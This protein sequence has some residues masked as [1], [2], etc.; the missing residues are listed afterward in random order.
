MTDFTDIV[1]LKCNSPS[2]PSLQMMA[3][4]QVGAGGGSGYTSAP[5]VTIVGG[6]AT[7]NATATAT[8]NSTYKT[9]TS[10][11]VNSGGG[12]Y[13]SF[14]AVYISNPQE[15]GDTA[16]AM[17]IVNFQTGIV[18]Q[19]ILTGAKGKAGGFGYIST[20]TVSIS[21]AGSGASA[22]AEYEGSPYK[23]VTRINI[24][25]EGSGYSPDT[26]IV[27]ISEPTD[28]S[29]PLADRKVATA[30]AV[31]EDEYIKAIF[32][33][34]ELPQG[35][36][37]ERFLDTTTG[38][39]YN[40][41]YSE[42]FLLT[43]PA[44]GDHIPFLGTNESFLVKKDLQVGG[45]VASQQG[46]IVLNHG[47]R[48]KPVLSSPPCISLDSS[49]IPYPYVSSDN[50][51]PSNAEPGQLYNSGG[52]HKMFDGS[53]WNPG[54]FSGYYDTLFLFQFDGHTPA[55]LDLGNLTVHGDLLVDGEIDASVS[56]LFVNGV[57]TL[58][59]DNSIK[60][61]TDNH[62][63]IGE[64][65]KMWQNMYTR[66]L[67]LG[68]N[69]ATPTPQYLTFSI[70]NTGLIL[71]ITSSSSSGSLLP[72]SG[73]QLDLGS[74]S[75]KWNAIYC[76]N[77]TAN[78]I[79]S[80]TT[81]TIN[82]GLTVSGNANIS[83]YAQFNNNA[84]LTWVNTTTLA[85]TDVNGVTDKAGLDVGSIFINS[86]QPLN[87]GSPAGININCP[88]NIG[89]SRGTSGQVLTS[90]GSGSSPTWQ[91]SGGWNGGT[92]STPIIIDYN[93]A[94]INLDIKNTSDASSIL[95]ISNRW[96]TNGDKAWIYLGDN[97][98][99]YIACTYGGTLDFQS[100]NGFTWGTQNGSNRMVLDASGNC[101]LT[102]AL[103]LQGYAQFQENMVSREA[104]NN[105]QM[106]SN[107]NRSTNTQASAS[108]PSWSIAVGADDS[109][110]FYRMPAA[111]GWSQLGQINASGSFGVAG[112]ITAGSYIVTQQTADNSLHH[113]LFGQSGKG[114]WAEYL[115]GTTSGGN[116]GND[117]L[118]LRYG[119]DASF[120][121]Q[122]LK[123][124]RSNGAI[125][126]ANSC[127]DNGV[128]SMELAGYIKIGGDNY[129]GWSNGSGGWDVYMR[130]A[131]ANVLAI[132]NGSGG[133]GAL[134]CSIM[135][136]DYWQPTATGYL[137]F[138]NH[139]KSYSTGLGIYPYGDNN[140]SLGGNGAGVSGYPY[141]GSVYANY[142]LYKTSHG[143][144]DA[145]D[146]LDLI[147]RM[148]TKTDPDGKEIIDPDTIKHLL[149]GD[150]FCEV[151]KV[152]GWHLSVQRKMVEK[153]DENDAVNAELQKRI[154][155][156][157]AEVEQLKTKLT[158][159]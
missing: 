158:T 45:L 44:Y 67:I 109:F 64:S 33:T 28:T 106:R 99:N 142:L 14:P 91:T 71:T 132:D 27:T 154:E 118:L 47:F 24:T 70:D 16:S 126:T 133:L 97:N 59:D 78:S 111:G 77:L 110:I 103:S 86:L 21:G 17:A 18:E 35:Q 58:A 19:I 143:A 90:N 119:D 56:G 152:N 36:S 2:L 3:H 98:A 127:L 75:Q 135:K 74:S 155:Q 139:M 129:I 8:I 6:G 50:Y 136:C 117:Y 114:F 120:L 31:I 131:A 96:T 5:S 46:A 7:T 53:S 68:N 105:F 122:G 125:Y 15:A 82:N 153:F 89:G 43:N 88:L 52:T 137:Y 145:Y 123:I 115:W 87:S 30:H 4:L 101:T 156:L 79:S 1:K 10:I 22:T 12:G 62:S 107:W 29:I 124:V 20:P 41:R 146:D 69:S 39:G 85:V 130:R 83:G 13:T 104:L 54:N 102:G 11:T 94:S 80:A 48:G 34:G 121:G 144:F 38:E 57:L 37:A 76:T 150:G 23:R 92:V 72:A 116:A 128:G 141:W 159:A 148:K 95:R 157:N 134:N 26:T 93:G 100:Y 49:G 51:L 140:G 113:Y 55:H 149:D 25:N 108:Y 61:N 42:L 9:V 147:R 73:K 65:T 112:T 66:N 60:P 63:S 84:K 32:L 138:M 151:G 81:L 40:Q